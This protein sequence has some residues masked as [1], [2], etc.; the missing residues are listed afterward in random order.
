MD[1][2]LITRVA[3]SDRIVVRLPNWM[4]DILMA[5]PFLMAL[6][7][8]TRRP[9][10]GLVRERYAQ[11][12]AWCPELD[13]VWTFPEGPRWRRWITLR[14]QRPAWVRHAVG[15]VLP[16]SWTSAIDLWVSGVPWR[17]GY[18][19]EARSTML[20][21]ALRGRWPERRHEAEHFLHLLTPWTGVP[22]GL[23]EPIPPLHVN[24]IPTVPL[25]G[26]PYVFV[27]A[28]ASRR[29]RAWP[30]DRYR[31]VVAALRAWGWTV[32][33][34]WPRWQPDPPRDPH[35]HVLS[36]VSLAHLAAWIRHAR[37]FIGNDGG[38]AHLA[39]ALGVPVLVIYGPGHPAR[40]RPITCGAPVWTVHTRWPC[41][42][43]RQ[44]F[45]RECTP[46]APDLPACLDVITVPHVLRRVE[47]C[48][49][50]LHNSV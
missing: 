2:D 3:A 26:T 24:G 7:I 44:K 46:V 14:R 36:E 40:H 23:R 16:H 5:R 27:Y 4:G 38:P 22:P 42:P 30:A 9:I 11:L 1:T 12:A 35:I 21:H 17:Y 41:S 32:V 45:F 18:A 50:K 43:C 39:A 37:L 29:P 25:S 49:Q 10:V 33:L 34:D 31:R 8:R 28:H 15:I 6:R 20:T 13:G 47:E 48:L 19:T